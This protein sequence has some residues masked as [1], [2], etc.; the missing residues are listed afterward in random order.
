MKM[1]MHDSKTLKTTK[2]PAAAPRTKEK[3]LGEATRLMGHGFSLLP[4][5]MPAAGDARSGK[6]PACKHGVK[7]AT[8]DPKKFKKLI[9]PLP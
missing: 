8:N 9:E 1:N 7:D 5:K 2:K 4:I 3:L 6:A